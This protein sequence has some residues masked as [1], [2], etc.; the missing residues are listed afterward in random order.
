LIRFTSRKLSSLATAFTASDPRLR[1]HDWEHFS[2]I[3]NLRGPHNGIPRVKEIGA[4]SASAPTK[5]VSSG[6]PRT[7]EKTPIV[8]PKV[9]EDDGDKTIRAK[10]ISKTKKVTLKLSRPSSVTPP[11]SS[12]SSMSTPFNPGALPVDN[13]SQSNITDTDPAMIPLPTSRSV[14]PFPSASSSITA[15]NT[16]SQSSQHP[17]R[18]SFTADSSSSVP[19][20]PL[21]LLNSKLSPK[22]TF[23][24][25]EGDDY[26]DT[27][28]SSTGSGVG[29]VKR[30]RWEHTLH[31]STQL[32]NAMDVDRGTAPHIAPDD[33]PPLSPK[34][35][36]EL[37]ALS[38]LTSD[39]E[40]DDDAGA[41]IESS[42]E[43]DEDD[44][45]DDLEPNQNHLQPTIEPTNS[46][47]TARR[48][49]T[50]LAAQ[51]GSREKPLTRRERK[52]LGLPKKSSVAKAR[53]GGAGAGKIVIPGG[54]YRR[55]DPSAPGSEEGK[56]EWKTNG[57]GRLDVR[58][59]RELK[60]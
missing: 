26:S 54:R 46:S 50:R 12:V 9:E 16:N 45:D 34:A 40:S 20:E 27:A 19:L 14:S 57:T 15:T 60:I 58:G 23:A 44:C 1:Y 3:R 24:E 59:F 42:Q 7:Q 36:S 56:D 2:S 53:V 43:D 41:D 18:E 29:A 8:T 48:K 49:S 17:L 39:A 37:S 30:T 10:P 28:T 13:N 33:A 51:N 4:P 25:S 55:D 35:L 52:K 6:P 31:L 11:M 21:K 47:H 22:R 38:P 32:S 5:P